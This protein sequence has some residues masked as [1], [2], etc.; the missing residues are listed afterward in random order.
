V[1]SITGELMKK[2]DKLGRFL[3]PSVRF[4]SGLSIIPGYFLIDQILLKLLLVGIFALLASLAGKR[5]RFLYF[6]MMTGSIVFFHL[7]TPVGRIML[8]AGPF[9][10]TEGALETGFLKGITLMGLV[11]LSL[12]SVTPSLKLPGKLGGLLGRMF[13]YFEE[14]IDSRKRIVPRNIIGSLDQILM[15]IFPPGELPEPTRNDRKGSQSLPLTVLYVLT[16]EI[17]VWGSVL[18]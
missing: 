1:E 5:I 14:I 18:I 6:I 17:I 10:I 16:L 13:Y 3:S 4:W 15:E 12:F 2:E 8:N 9:I 11:F 7:L